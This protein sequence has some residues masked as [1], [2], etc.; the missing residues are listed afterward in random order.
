VRT[1]F[2]RCQFPVEA[3]DALIAGQAARRR[4]RVVE[5]RERR[6]FVKAIGE[7]GPCVV[8]A[9][10]HGAGIVL[11][12]LKEVSK[13]VKALVLVEPGE[14]VRAGELVGV[15]GSDMPTLVVWGDY[16]S[17]HEVWPKIRKP[18]DEIEG[19]EVLDLPEE[20]I[21]GN[22]HFPMLDLN[23]DEVWEKI[24]Q[25]VEKDRK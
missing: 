3:L 9:H 2:E 14:V 8:V 11:G 12:A 19:V 22:T 24:M 21:R 16:L 13:L 5:E 25:W 4:G 7:V 23:S 20:G 6:G 18:Y 17:E 15:A 1:P 10:S